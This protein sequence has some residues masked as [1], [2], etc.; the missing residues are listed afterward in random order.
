[1]L[2]NNKVRLIFSSIC[3]WWVIPSANG[4]GYGAILRH[5]SA[6]AMLIGG[7]ET[8]WHACDDRSLSN[9]LNFYSA[10][11]SRFEITGVLVHGTEGCT[12]S[13]ASPLHGAARTGKPLRLHG[14]A[15][16][17][18]CCLTANRTSILQQNLSHRDPNEPGSARHAVREL[19]SSTDLHGMPNLDHCT[20][21]HGTHAA[22][23]QASRG[24]TSLHGSFLPF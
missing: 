12:G 21:L 10:C 24:C 20:E 19:Q 2:L 1:M 18:G 11:K 13:D 6:E 5:Q 9:I 7:D 15:R 23:S 16:M 22:A 3:D 4:A 8:S 17:Y 14:V